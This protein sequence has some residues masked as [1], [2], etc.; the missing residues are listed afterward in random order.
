MK[1]YFERYKFIAMLSTKYNQLNKISSMI[2][3]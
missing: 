1:S 3:L 2:G